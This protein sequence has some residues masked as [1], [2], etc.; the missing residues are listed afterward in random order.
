MFC[1]VKSS[2]TCI[3]LSAM[4]VLQARQFLQFLL[5]FLRL[6]LPVLCPDSPVLGH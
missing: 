6:L 3:E 5:V 4:C 2:V 1:I